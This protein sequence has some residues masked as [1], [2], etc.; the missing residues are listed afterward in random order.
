MAFFPR[1]DAQG[2]FEDLFAGETGFTLIELLVT[3]AVVVILATVAAP[4]FRDFFENRRLT[5]A[6]QTLY[7]DLQ[8]ARAESIKRNQTIFVKFDDSPATDWCYGLEEASTATS[9]DCADTTNTYCTID[10]VRRVTDVDDFPGVTMSA[11]SVAGSTITFDPKRGTLAP[12]GSIFF[13]NGS[14]NQM[15]IVMSLLGRVR[16][17]VPSGSNV[18]GYP[19]CPP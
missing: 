18:S 17:C 19:A 7:A 9:C 8:L 13:T 1:K 2:K 14:G 12:A 3:L 6:A 4:A 5:N 15:R 16:L 10:G 11:S